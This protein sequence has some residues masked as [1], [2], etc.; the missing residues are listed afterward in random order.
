MLK[1]DYSTVWVAYYPNYEGLPEASTLQEGPMDIWLSWYSPLNIVG[2]LWKWAHPPRWPTKMADIP[3]PA[4]GCPNFPPTVPYSC[5]TSPHTLVLLLLLQLSYSPP[6]VVLLLLCSLDASSPTLH[7]LPL[8]PPI[9]LYSSLPVTSKL[10]SMFTQLWSVQMSTCSSPRCW[11]W[12]EFPACLP[13]PFS[14]GPTRHLVAALSTNK[15]PSLHSLH[16]SNLS[17][18]LPTRQQYPSLEYQFTKGPGLSAHCTHSLPCA[19]AGTPSSNHVP[20]SS[21][22]QSVQWS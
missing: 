5:P 22:S 12:K 18:L 15:G 1:S 4:F 21:A 14:K 19:F 8:A 2:C 13:R 16:S 6:T 11:A 9:R 17:R 3:A 7:L 10:T 20:S